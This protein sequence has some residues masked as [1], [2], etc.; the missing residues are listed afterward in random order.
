MRACTKCFIPKGICC[1]PEGITIIRQKNQ[2]Q[3]NPR[4]NKKIK[5]KPKKK[6]HPTQKQT[7]KHK[8][9]ISL[10]VFSSCWHLSNSYILYFLRNLFFLECVLPDSSSIDYSQSYPCFGVGY[11]WFVCLFFLVGLFR[12]FFLC[13]KIKRIVLGA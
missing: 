1:K 6:P 10:S 9:P 4:T 8:N 11:F 13:I 3:Q 7:N 5:T 2:Q 12:D